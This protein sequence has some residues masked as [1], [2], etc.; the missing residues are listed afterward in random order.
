MSAGTTVLPVDSQ[1]GFEVGDTIV[2]GPGEPEEEFAEIAG[3]GSIITLE[4]IVNDHPAGTIIQVVVTT[5]TPKP[6][7]VTCDGHLATIVGTSHSE[8][9]FGTNGDDVIVAKGGHDLIIARRGDDIICAGDGNDLVV[10]GKGD[11]KVFGEDG[12]DLLLGD[13]GN[14]YLDG[15]NDFDICFGGGGVDTIT[16]CEWPKPFY[17][18]SWH[19]D[20][21]DHDD[22]DDGY[23]GHH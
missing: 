12:H 20:H 23:E 16:H 13:H 17:K 10:A 19:G 18:K 1:E 7:D 15:G 6:G 2:I 8:I 21:D 4:P 3:F 9:I 22:D 14:D 5:P 11:D